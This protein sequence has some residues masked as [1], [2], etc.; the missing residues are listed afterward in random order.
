MSARL[1]RLCLT[2]TALLLAASEASAQL[3]FGVAL[4][5]SGP[6][7]A[8]GRSIKNFKRAS[9]GKDEI[10]VSPKKPELGEKDTQNT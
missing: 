10:D 8:L 7:A 9:A 1:H 3:N 4:P 5:L 2:A 6:R